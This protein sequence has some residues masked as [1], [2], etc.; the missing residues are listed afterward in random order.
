MSKVI[1]LKPHARRQT[2]DPS[3]AR[4]LGG[5]IGFFAGYLGS[6]AAINLDNHPLHWLVAFIGTVLGILIGHLYA[7]WR[8]RK[9]A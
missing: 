6:M 8:N 1:P 9:T 7:Y 4:L 2:T 5:A 3:L